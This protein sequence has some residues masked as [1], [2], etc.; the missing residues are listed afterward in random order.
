MEVMKRNMAAYDAD[1]E[2]AFGGREK[3]GQ[4]R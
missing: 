2:N 1:M 4:L 3:I